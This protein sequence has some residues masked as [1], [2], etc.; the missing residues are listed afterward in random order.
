MSET[1]V[2]HCRMPDCGQVMKPLL[3]RGFGYF[4][5]FYLVTCENPSCVMYGQTLAAKD[6][7][8]LDLVPYLKPR[9]VSA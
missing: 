5:D 7:A 2:I 1:P 8:D 6:Y 3:Q 9:K 4:A